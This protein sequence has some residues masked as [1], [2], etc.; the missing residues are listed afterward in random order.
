MGYKGIWL[1]INASDIVQGIGMI[2]FFSTGRW[3][4][5]YVKHKIK[6]RSQGEP[7]EVT[8]E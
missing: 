7:V 8:A 6:L 4:E 2:F 3:K 1:G 5:V